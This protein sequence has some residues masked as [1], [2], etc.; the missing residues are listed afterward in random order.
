MGEDEEQW[1]EEEG[2]RMGFDGL[3]ARPSVASR[4]MAWRRRDCTGHVSRPVEHRESGG[5][6]AGEKEEMN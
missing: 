1:E 5:R 2:R 4:V 3:S 6:K